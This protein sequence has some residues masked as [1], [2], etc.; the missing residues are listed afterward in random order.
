MRCI[1]TAGPTY[2]PID[3]VRRLTNHSTGKLGTNLA[4]HL[5]DDG[6]E[7]ILLRGKMATFTEVIES[8][9]TRIF[10]TTGDLAKKLKQIAEEFPNSLAVFHTAAVSDFYAGS[11]FQK[12]TDGTLIPLKK[13]KLSTR[14]GK[15]LFE[16]CPTQ[17]ILSQLRSW[18]KEAQIFGWKYEVVGDRL[19]T[20]CQAQKQINENDTNACVINGAA[21]G[22]GF[23]LLKK[24]SETA[25]HFDN[26]KML[27]NALA[28]LINS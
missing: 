28:N 18:Y 22:E 5:A 4:K 17:K 2:E 6:H 8:L 21:Y 15:L 19:A 24:G 1:V 16:L 25:T 10:T 12:K 27:F 11:V 14:K 3:Q 23:G 7:V 9:D 20:I 13:D 26:A